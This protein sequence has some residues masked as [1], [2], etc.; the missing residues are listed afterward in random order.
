MTVTCKARSLPIELRQQLGI[1]DSF[2]TE[3]MLTIGKEYLVLG[4]SVHVAS[5]VFGG[6]P[7]LQL[8]D[9]AGRLEMVPTPLLEIK[10]AR[11]SGFWRAR[12]REDFGLALWPEEFYSDYFHDDLSDGAPEA[13]DALA[14]VIRK[15][16]KE[17]T[18]TGHKRQ[19]E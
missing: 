7:V 18:T 13:K 15:L 10:D 11:P 17:A 12:Q 5:V 4:L 1:N 14:A 16:Q 8:V 9:D 19:P 3:Y 6:S 2:A